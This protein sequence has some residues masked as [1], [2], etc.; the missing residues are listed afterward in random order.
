MHTQR[1]HFI[2]EEPLTQGPIL[3]WMSRDQR[4]RDNWAILYAQHLAR[5]YDT[6]LMVLFCVVP[7]FL[8]ATRRQ[9]SFMLKGLKQVNEALQGK[10]IPFHLQLGEPQKIIPAFIKEHRVSTLVVDFD[11]LRVK[12]QWQEQVRLRISIPMC[13]VDAHNIVPCRV[14]SPKQEYGAYTLRPKIKNL[15]PE[16]LDDFPRLRKQN[17]VKMKKNLWAAEAIL[18]Q[19]KIDHS[20]AETPGYEPG[21]QAAHK[22]LDRFIKKKLENYPEKRNDPGEDAVSGLSPYLHFGQIAAQRVAL[23]VIAA[24]APEPAKEAFLEEL[25]VRREL[26]DN[27]CFYCRDYDTSE[28]FPEW[29]R[30][31]LTAHAQDKRQYVYTMVELEKGQTHDPLWNAAQKEMVQ[32]GRMHGYMRMYWAKKILEWN[33][34]PQLAQTAA[35]YLND[36]YEL[37]GRDPNGYTGVAWSIGGVHDRAWPEREVFGKIRYMNDRG[38]R[39]KFDVDRYIKKVAAYEH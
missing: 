13:E 10:G 28:G 33:V 30:K 26:A 20:V 9:Y 17:G 4:I 7:S 1:I 27:Y 24:D 11:P 25:I 15:L 32:Q 21:E 38:C 22:V 23:K 16:F 2:R 5:Q 36:K 12:Q 19:L 6:S 37:D 8:Q 14:A 18:A 3:Y 39:S 34:S 35:I 29:A 31:T